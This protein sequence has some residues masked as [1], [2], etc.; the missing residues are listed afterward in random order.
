LSGVKLPART[1]PIGKEIDPEA[2]PEEAAK[3]VIQKA[4]VEDDEYKQK[5]EQS[6]Y[7]YKLIKL[8]SS[9]VECRIIKLCNC[10]V[11]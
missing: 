2:I 8:K 6:Y 7:G 3:E 5:G 11:L 1:K 9:K 10:S 4:K